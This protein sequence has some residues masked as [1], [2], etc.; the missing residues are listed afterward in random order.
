MGRDPFRVL[1]VGPEASADEVHAA[2]RSL[3]LVA[4]PDAGGSHEKMLEINE[5]REA[6][7][8]LLDRRAAP[9]KMPRVP[10]DPL[11]R[12]MRMRRE[13]SAFTIDVLPVDAFHALEIVAAECGPTIQD[14]P[15][16]MIEFMLHDAPITGAVDA[17]C[18][19]DLVPEAG[20]TTV[21]VA[22]G[23]AGDGTPP[24]IESLRDLLVAGLNSIDWPD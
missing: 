16:Y 9:S 23:T 18:R 13:E 17:W 22:I 24:S 7:L 20:A 1:G 10:A 2:W 5:A 12:R 8:G 4:H 6:A 11:E 3:S 21:H 19:C 14:E 15:P